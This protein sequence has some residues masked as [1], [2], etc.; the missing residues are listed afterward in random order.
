MLRRNLRK[1]KSVT[2]TSWSLPRLSDTQKLYAANDAYAA[3]RVHL[4]LTLTQQE[5]QALLLGR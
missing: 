1:S 4:A 2:T 5:R 3:L